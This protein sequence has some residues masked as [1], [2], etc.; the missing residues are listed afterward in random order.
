M[1]R[2]EQDAPHGSLIAKECGT[3]KTVSTLT[4]IAAAAQKTKLYN[5]ANPSNPKPFRATLIVVPAN[6]IEV[7][8]ADITKF[9]KNRL[10]VYQYYGSPSFVSAD[11]QKVLICGQPE[12]ELN[13][14][15]KKLDPNAIKVCYKLEFTSLPYT[16]DLPR[17]A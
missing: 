6:S 11:R 7:W 14:L 17:P 2:Q 9:F 4:L 3:G 10:H 5:M 12:S 13:P 16:D 1:Y 15:L 8:M